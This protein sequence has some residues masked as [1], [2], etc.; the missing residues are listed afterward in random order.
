[1]LPT[2]ALARAAPHQIDARKGV[3]MGNDPVDTNPFHHIL[4][5]IEPGTVLAD[6]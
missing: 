5:S 2:R 3:A 6:G 4:E 1:M